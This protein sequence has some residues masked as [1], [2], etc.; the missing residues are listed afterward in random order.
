MA[1]VVNTN[2]A[3]LNAQRQL[4][5]NTNEMSDAMERLSSGKRINTA[6]DDAAGLAIS[7]RMTSQVKGLTMAIRNA[8]DGISLVQTAEGSLDEVTDMLQR[9]REL[10]IQSS[11][12]ANSDADR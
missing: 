11:N 5:S 1:L 6:S 10:A 2:L 12:L 4:N 7:T 3:S 9:M 8:N